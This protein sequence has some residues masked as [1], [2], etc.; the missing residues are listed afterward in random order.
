MKQPIPLYALIQSNGAL[1]EG[2]KTIREGTLSSKE[3]SAA[4]CDGF[5]NDN[6]ISFSYVLIYPTNEYVF[7]FQKK[8]S[9]AE[10]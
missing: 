10:I 2:V 4:H 3:E 8:I 6:T 1:K 9:C 5:H 7:V